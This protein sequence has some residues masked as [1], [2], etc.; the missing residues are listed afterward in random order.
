[1]TSQRTTKTNALIPTMFVGLTTALVVL[2]A[3]AAWSQPSGKSSNVALQGPAATAARE[4]LR[5]TLPG[6][7]TEPSDADSG[8]LLSLLPVLTFDGGSYG[9]A[10]IAAADFNG[11]GKPDIVVAG[12]ICSVLC[13]GAVVGILLGNGDG[14]FQSAVNY[15]TGGLL[16]SLAVADVNGDGKLDVVV[17]N[18]FCADGSQ[19]CVGVLLG[20]GDGTFQAVVTYNSG[21]FMGRSLALA[22]LN[23]DGKLEVAVAHFCASN[24]NGYCPFDEAGLIGVLLGNG[25][26]TFQT[27]ITY[28]PAGYGTSSIAVA[29][30]NGDGKADLLVA[31]QCAAICEFYGEGSVGILLGNG[32]GTFQP[33]V[34]YDPAGTNSIYVTVADL[35]G[36]NK[37]DLVVENAGSVS[38]LLGND[39][40]TFQPPVTYNTGGGTSVSLADLNGDGK[41][42][43]LTVGASTVDV[44]LGNGDGTF[45]TTLQTFASGGQT[46]WSVIAADLNGDGWP[47]VELYQTGSHL[48][49]LWGMASL[50]CC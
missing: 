8:L 31:N 41:V 18:E 21:G 25:D 13:S 29:D 39:R 47:D 2:A 37:L 26:G 43:M 5:P 28:S 22:D 16:A 14:T 33:A 27:A 44:L 11:D 46:P 49:M 32:D 42:D 24:G 48:N 40:G 9:S 15:E 19:S 1:M 17:V 6:A 3:S 38:V 30:I 12:E 7:R 50:G 10:S 45:Q 36:D 34:T 4:Q 23:G 35:N 20:N